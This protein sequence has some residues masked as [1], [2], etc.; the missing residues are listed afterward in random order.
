MKAFY[1][2]I[3]SFKRQ[4]L[5]V[6]K[7]DLPN[8]DSPFHYHPEYELTYIIKGEG[9]RY[10]GMKMQEFEAG[11]LVLLGSNLPHCWLNRPTSDDGNV[12]AYVIQFDKFLFENSFFHLPEFERLQAFL[13]LSQQGIAFDGKQFES[14]LKIIYEGNPAKQLLNLLELLLELQQANSRSILDFAPNEAFDQKRFQAVFAYIIAHFKEKI[15]LDTVAGIAGLSPSS[16]CRYFRN[17]TGRTLLDVVLDY[18]LEA[19]VQLLVHTS[20]QISE[21]AYASGFESIPYFNRAFKKWKGMSPGAFRATFSGNKHTF[22]ADVRK[23]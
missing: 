23:V 21:I 10:V 2:H 13:Q 8:F 18:R 11:E 16:F 19:V 14:R 17:A 5:V 7:I 22:P 6:R 1:E 3:N 12:S 20:D 4:S 15:E 9:I